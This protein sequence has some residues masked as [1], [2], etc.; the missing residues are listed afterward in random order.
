VN[1][2]LSHFF[3]HV[4]NMRPSFL[5]C[6]VP[7]PLGIVEPQNEQFLKEDSVALLLELLLTISFAYRA[8][9]VLKS[10]HEPILWQAACFWVQIRA[11]S[12]GQTYLP[13]RSRNNCCSGNLPA[14]HASTSR[15]CNDANRRTTFMIYSF[16]LKRLSQIILS[17]ARRNG[18]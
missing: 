18:Q 13:N 7:L 10:L 1:K 12:A 4:H 17:Y 9:I 16:D 2:F 15:T 8:A 3:E 11:W 6:I 5:T 14:N